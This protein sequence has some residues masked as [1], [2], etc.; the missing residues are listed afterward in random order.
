MLEWNL[1]RT[2]A[3]DAIE[4]KDLTVDDGLLPTFGDGFVPNPP[5]GR[6]RD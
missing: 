6:E 1:G 2:R 3:F 5:P 4:G